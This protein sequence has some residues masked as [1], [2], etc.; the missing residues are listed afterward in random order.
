MAKISDKLSLRIYKT[1]K[2]NPV[3]I[4]GEDLRI[5]IRWEKTRVLYTFIVEKGL[6]YVSNKE[7]E[8]QKYM[9]VLADQK[10]DMLKKAIVRK[11]K[12]KRVIAKSSYNP[13]D[14]KLEDFEIDSLLGKTSKKSKKSKTKKKTKKKVGKKN[15]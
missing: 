10:I 12:K 1:D 4:Q 3:F 11:K 8:D 9:R 15:G 7:T 6:W 2:E 14:Y 5:Q 13:A